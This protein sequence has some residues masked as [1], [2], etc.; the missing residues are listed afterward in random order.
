MSENESNKS[1]ISKIL[2]DKLEYSNDIELKEKEILNCIKNG[3]KEMLF[4][5]NKENFPIFLFFI[6]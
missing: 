2:K 6:L 3:K 4:N 1:E 5:K